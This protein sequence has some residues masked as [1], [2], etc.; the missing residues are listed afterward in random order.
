M[1]IILM[2]I[3]AIILGFIMYILFNHFDYKFIWSI[4]SIL[5]TSI[6]IYLSGYFTLPLLLQ[7]FCICALASVLFTF[8]YKQTYKTTNTLWMFIMITLGLELVLWILQN[9]LI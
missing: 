6:Y 2:I 3:G 4:V 5:F 1:E 8:L 9:Y 7:A